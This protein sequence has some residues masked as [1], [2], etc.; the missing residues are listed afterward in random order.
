MSP[1]RIKKIYVVLNNSAWRVVIVRDDAFWKLA[2]VCDAL[3]EIFFA[4]FCIN[5]Q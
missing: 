3:N 2:I 1:L 4:K 5:A